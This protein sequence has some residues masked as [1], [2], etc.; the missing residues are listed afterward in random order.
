MTERNR[1]SA[2]WR[3][4]LFWGLLWGMWEATVGHFVHLIKLPGL[5]GF[6]MFPAAFFFMS[7]AFVR[8][9]RAES[10]FPAACVAAGIKL[11]DIFI[12]GAAAQA[13]V[14]PA[15]AIILEALA[16]TGFYTLLGRT[17]S[18]PVKRR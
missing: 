8:S 12:P 9:G 16:V 18:I 14:N 1:T 3:A 15:L 17:E 6:I 5:P 4:A 7:R 13:S 10:I 2:F 11:L